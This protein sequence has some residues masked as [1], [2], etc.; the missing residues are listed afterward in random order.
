MVK[1]RSEHYVNNKELLEALI[2]YRSKVE[3][4]FVSRYGREPTKE[5][6]R[7]HIKYTEVDNYN[8][9]ENSS[10]NMSDILDN[11]DNIRHDIDNDIQV[12]DNIVI[13]INEVSESLSNSNNLDEPENIVSDPENIVS[14]PENIVSEPENDSP[15][16]INISPNTRKKTLINMK[17]SAV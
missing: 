6:I 13:D 10:D 12:N 16:P 15:K 17:H 11:Y 5:E 14:E 1:K 8:D 9:S 3:E 4:D 7:K 2:V